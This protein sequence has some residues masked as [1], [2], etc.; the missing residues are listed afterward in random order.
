MLSLASKVK[1]I[2]RSDDDLV[3]HDI[4]LTPHTPRG[5]MT[6]RTPRGDVT[7]RG[8]ASIQGGEFSP[9]SDI[10]FD[11][12]M[13][14]TDLRELFRKY[15]EINHSEEMLQFIE[16]VDRFKKV[17]IE[18][19][20]VQEAS[21]IISKFIHGLQGNNQINLDHKIKDAILCSFDE[22]K[23]GE[24]CLGDIFRD[25]RNVV[26]A[27]MKEAWF[28]NFLQS[29]LLKKSLEAQSDVSPISTKTRGRSFLNV[30]R[31]R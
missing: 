12:V 25:A 29:E 21:I 3:G 20:R 28:L 8:D 30:L 10:D 6:P 1:K 7:P 31:V 16:H 15:L 5:D 23:G 26:K 24:L 19:D 4:S 2:F 18:A 14:I 22:C 11:M 9:R 27:E 17:S 13:N